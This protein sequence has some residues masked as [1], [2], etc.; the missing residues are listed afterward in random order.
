[1]GVGG[2]VGRAASSVGAGFLRGT[3]WLSGFKSGAIG[4]SGAIIIRVGNFT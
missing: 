3:L 2:I 1:M 4:I